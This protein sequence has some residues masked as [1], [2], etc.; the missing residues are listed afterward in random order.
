M[1]SDFNFY[2]KRMSSD[3]NFV[4]FANSEAIDLTPPSARFFPNIFIQINTP[5]PLSL[6]S[7]EL[8]IQRSPTTDSLIWISKMAK[9][10]IRSA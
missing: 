1:R 5:V 8:T 4:I 9:I 6:I 2:S 7:V 10:I 3:V